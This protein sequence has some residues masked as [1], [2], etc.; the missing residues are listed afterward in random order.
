MAE[1]GSIRPKLV[2]IGPSLGPDRAQIGR[3]DQVE[4]Y[5]PSRG[6]ITILKA[7]SNASPSHLPPAAHGR[8]P[9][10][11]HSLGPAATHARQSMPPPQSHDWWPHGSAYAGAAPV[12]RP[13]PRRSPPPPQSTPVRAPDAGCSRLSHEV[14]AL[15]ATTAYSDFKA[16]RGSMSPVGHAWR[17]TGISRKRIAERC[18]QHLLP[19]TPAVLL[20]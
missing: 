10:A 3:T 14:R 16:T 1:I 15:R 8:T 20:W 7:I 13:I 4:N 17:S 5:V 19:S 12:R 18:S 2:D 9:R 6:G 11:H